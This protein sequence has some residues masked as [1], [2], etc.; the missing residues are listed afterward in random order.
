M[1]QEFEHKANAFVAAEWW[2]HRIPTLMEIAEVNIKTAA[3][4]QAVK[5][6]NPYEGR[7]D[8]WQLSETV[9]EFLAR[10]PPATTRTSYDLP[11]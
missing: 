7:R 10:L 9:K 6:Y 8:S 5:L 4:K 11:W 1:K 3:P 2:E